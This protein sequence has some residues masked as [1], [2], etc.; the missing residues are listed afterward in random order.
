[1]RESLWQKYKLYGCKNFILY[2]TH[3]LWRRLYLQVIRGSYSQMREDLVIDKLLGYKKN[4]FYVD[5]GAYDPHKFSNTKRFY[6]KGWTGI[7][8]EPNPKKH[9]KFL[10]KRENDI[11]LNIGIDEN[12]GT[13]TFYEF[14]PAVSSTFSKDEA[15]KYLEQG[16]KLL[17]KIESKTRTLETVLKRHANGK[18]IDFMTIDTEGLEMEV[19]KGNKWSEYRPKII[20]IESVERNISLDKQS[21]I[22]AQEKF[23][24]NIGYKKY[25][26]NSIN[27]IYMDVDP[28]LSMSEQQQKDN[29]PSVA[30]MRKV[31]NFIAK[32]LKNTRITPNAITVLNFLIFTPLIIYFLIRG[33]HIGILIALFL[34]FVRAIFDLVDGSLAKMKSL[35]SK[36]GAWLDSS[37]DEV[38]QNLIFLAVIIGVVNSTGNWQWFLPGLVV[39]FGQNMANSIC[40]RY[41]HVF[42][43]DDYSGSEKFN[44]KFLELN[45]ISR[46][47]S[48]LKNIIVP[49][50]PFYIFFFTCRYLLVLGILFNRLDIF[51]IAFAITINV[52][53]LVMYFLYLRYLYN[54]KSKLYTIKFLNEIEKKEI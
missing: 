32:I 26:Q 6:L 28:M 46:L 47:D 44:N 9:S 50:N 16:C 18:K 2:G 34:I 11:N 42:G 24:S 54:T 25:Y 10:K 43:F 12:N 21:N 51:L 52:R 31:A 8:I 20:C 38:F 7:N 41:S 3:E 14:F 30:L 53:W 4:G 39:L 33:T 5:V 17:N 15:K 40:A 45:K 37:L 48:F 49:V 23:L 29:D 35:Q 13:A 19:L 1:M 22:D 27:S 36:F